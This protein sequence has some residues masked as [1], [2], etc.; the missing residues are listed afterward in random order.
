MSN[1]EFI[2]LDNLS[3]FKEETDSSYATKAEVATKQDTLV[4]GTNIKTLNNESLLGSGNIDLASSPMVEITW[5]ELKALRDAGELVPG[6]QYRI[7]DYQCTTVTSQTSSAGY[8]FDII[9]VADDE[10]RLNENARAMPHPGVER[11]NG[12]KLEQ[13]RLWYCLDNDKNR[14]DWVDSTN[15]KGV[16]YRMIDEYNNDAPYDFKNIRFNQKFTFGTLADDLSTIQRWRNT[17]TGTREIVCY[18]NII[19]P[20]YTT[21]YSNH[22]TVQSLNKTVIKSDSLSIYVSIS[23]NVFGVNNHDNVIGVDGSSSS[24]TSWYG[25][26]IGSEF[27]GNTIQSGYDNIIGNNCYNNKIGKG[28][29]ANIIDWGM[30]GNTIGDQFYENKV[31]LGFG[32][33]TVGNSF[34]YNTI[35]SNVNGDK[36][37][38]SVQYNTLLGQNWYVT[39]PSYTE[40]CTLDMGVRYLEMTTSESASSSNKIQNA[41][42]HV[43]IQ[44]PAYNDRITVE[45]P[46][47]LACETD[48]YL[49]ESGNIIYKKNNDADNSILAPIY[50]ATSTYAVGDAVT[51]NNQLYQCIVA[52]ETAEAWT[53]AHWQ[54]ATVADLIAGS[55]GNAINRGY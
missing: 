43:G 33:N 42:L 39:I 19:K 27:W 23:N 3:T 24:G 45:L 26:K 44:G 22:K 16:I 41:H 29:A 8:A 18:N 54:S 21:D 40:H 32:G 5:A 55:I 2:S 11:F 14:F 38:E 52:I 7:T 49:D 31:G 1:K 46:T 9:V 13:W 15:G 36:I 53:A 35:I 51:Y 34:M 48:V 6:M 25:N 12:N 17:S 4:S 28:F 37:G 50:D 47:N 20:Y 10:N 30:Y